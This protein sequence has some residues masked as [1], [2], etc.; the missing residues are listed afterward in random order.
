MLDRLLPEWMAFTMFGHSLQDYMVAVLTFVLVLIGLK[1]FINIVTRV[2]KKIAK[3]ED[4]KQQIVTTKEQIRGWFYVVVALLVTLQ[5]LTLPE[6]AGY[7]I[8][9]VLTT[10]ILIQILLVVSHWVR[11]SISHSPIGRTPDGKARAIGSN[12]VSM[13]IIFVWA[14]A[15]LFLLDNFGFNIATIL[16]GLGVGGIAIGLALQSILGDVF[17]SFAIALD[18]PFEIGDFIIVNDFMGSVDY[19]GLK[20]TRLRSLGGELLI[21]ANKDLVNSRIR[22]YKQMMERRIVFTFGVTYDT[23]QDKLEAIPDKVREIINSVDRTRFDRAHFAKF[24]DFSL[25]FEVVYYVLLPDFGVYMDIQQEINFKL[26][27]TLMANQVNFAFP[28]TTLDIPEKV[29]QS[30][31]GAVQKRASTQRE[32]LQHR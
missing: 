6:K 28:T 16:A 10:L 8:N 27:R 1:L 20:T 21:F 23:D 29:T 2:L 5:S 19:V 4:L 24:A 13:T 9:L 3:P 15:F 26:R 7:F 32:Q 30:L 17:A 18:K 22:N 25:V 11:F 31:V 14:I 12:L